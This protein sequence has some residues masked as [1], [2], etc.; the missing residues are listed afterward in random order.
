METAGGGSMIGWSSHTLF[1]CLSGGY[2]LTKHMT[3]LK[4]ILPVLIHLYFKA[5]QSKQKRKKK[6]L[7]TA[8]RG[9]AGVHIH[10]C[11]PGGRAAGNL[12]P[13]T[14]WLIQSDL[15]FI[16]QWLRERRGGARW[17]GAEGMDG[18]TFSWHHWTGREHKIKPGTRL[19]SVC[20]VVCTCLLPSPAWLRVV[21]LSKFNTISRVRRDDADPPWGIS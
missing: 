2:H 15:H 19:L 7:P 18:K 9:R 11:L 1:S 14:P 6:N 4:W 20:V 21:S 13:W 17:D 16:P 8:L 10:T 5:K 12:P 3:P